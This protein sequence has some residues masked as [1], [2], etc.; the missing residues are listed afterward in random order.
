[1]WSRTCRAVLVAL[2][3]CAIAACSKAQTDEA[4]QA[5]TTAAVLAR[6]PASASD[7]AAVYTTNCSSCHQTD[8][9][10]I[11]GAF[12]PLADNAFVRGN[13]D[14]VIRIVKYGQS[15]K[16][17]VNGVAYDGTMPRW[18][19]LISDREIAAVVTYIRTSWNNHAGAVSLADVRSVP[20]PR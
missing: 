4:S 5:R 20:N 8:G 16:L 2:M 13:P 19:Q 18:S 10:G 3:A 1:M 11:A 12:P 15:G 14:A 7:G 9:R 6:N 17:A